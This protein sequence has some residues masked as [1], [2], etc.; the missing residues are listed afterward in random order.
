RIDRDRV[1]HVALALVGVLATAWLVMLPFWPLAQINPFGAIDALRGTDVDRPATARFGG[2][3]VPTTSLPRSYLAVWFGLT[4]PETSFLCA[5]LF[6][7]WVIRGRRGPSRAEQ[8]AAA[9][10]ALFTALP[11][12][13]VTVQR[14][15]FYDGVRHELFVVPLFAVLAA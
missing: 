7:A 15:P 12:L 3:L 1:Q 14:A 9:R 2:A 4:L 5:A 8:L 6:L 10:L 13:L 11:L